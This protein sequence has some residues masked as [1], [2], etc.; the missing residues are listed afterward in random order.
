VVELACIVTSSWVARFL[1]C[2]SGESDFDFAPAPLAGN[3]VE[4][5][6]EAP[7]S[8]LNVRVESYIANKIDLLR[9]T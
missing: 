7:R 9:Q 6:T 5:G 1:V 4:R 2:L 8:I 3:S